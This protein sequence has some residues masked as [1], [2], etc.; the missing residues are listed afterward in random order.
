MNEFDAVTERYSTW[1]NVRDSD[2]AC[3]EQM[4]AAGLGLFVRTPETVNAAEDE[5][6]PGYRKRWTHEDYTQGMGL[7]WQQQ[8]DAKI[9]AVANERAGDMGRSA[10]ATIEILVHDMLN[11][12]FPGGPLGPDG[13]TLFATDHPFYRGGG[14]QSNMLNPV[15]PLTV[16]NYRLALTTFRRFYDHTGVRRLQMSPDGVLVAPENEHNADEI[17]KSAGRPDTA[18]RADNVTRNATTVM[19]SEHLTDPKAWFMH[20]AK[21]R[22]KLMVFFRERFHTW[23]TEDERARVNWMFA[24]FALSY[25]WLDYL[26]W[27]GSNPA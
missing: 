14:A 18:N 4:T 25:G 12:G 23:D 6:V 27:L 26:G 11:R 9:M 10:L 21:S 2:S 7:S 24:A 1:A 13:K 17:I 20:I 16:T 5:F 8:R 19:V 15:G 22:G 3:E